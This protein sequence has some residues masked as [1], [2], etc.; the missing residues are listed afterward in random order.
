MNA[1]ENFDRGTQDAFARE[2]APPATE[3]PAA[4][5]EVVLGGDLTRFLLSALTGPQ[6]PSR[7]DPR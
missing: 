2:Q 6:G 1:G 5:L 7:T 3:P 4:R